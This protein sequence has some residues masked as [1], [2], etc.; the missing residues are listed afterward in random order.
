MLRGAKHKCPHIS[1]KK[2]IIVTILSF[3]THRPTHIDQV[4]CG[5]GKATQSRTLE[6]MGLPKWKAVADLGLT[7][8]GLPG[9]LGGI[10][11][12][13]VGKFEDPLQKSSLK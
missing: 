1:C 12:E 13:A 8:G 2:V 11:P 10:Y 7:E 3:N 6:G 4:L 9:D 5:D